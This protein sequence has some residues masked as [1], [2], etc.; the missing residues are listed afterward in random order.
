MKRK[1]ALPAVAA[2]ALLGWGGCRLLQTPPEERVRAAFEA[3]AESL[4]KR[5]ADEGP[6][7]TV[8][9]RGDFAALLDDAVTVTV[10]E[11]G[12]TGTRTREE[13]TSRVFA[14]RQAARI[15]WV[16]F[17]EIDVRV[18]PDG[19]SATATC[20]ARLSV[21]SSWSDMHEEIRR[22]RA[23]LVRKGDRW[24]FAEAEVFPAASNS[25][26]PPPPGRRRRRACRTGASGGPSS[27]SST[28]S[29]MSPPP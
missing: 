1:Y 7:R 12:W 25:F 6:L 19:R 22:V 14:N 28:V 3:L 8:S 2:A 17:G 4:D 20:D 29:S 18:A 13:A 21:D 27:R 24:L 9:K 16:F 23:R 15:M 5:G 11:L 10:R 26:A